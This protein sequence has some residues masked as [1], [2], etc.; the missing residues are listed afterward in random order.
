MTQEG[1]VMHTNTL[2]SLA[3][4]RTP[5]PCNL[6]YYRMLLTVNVSCSLQETLAHECELKIEIKRWLALKILLK[7]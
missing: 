1:G 7:F 2:G 4:E 6:L 3:D 5:Q